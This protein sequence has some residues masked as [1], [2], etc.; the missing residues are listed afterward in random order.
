LLELS[1]D[2]LA[3]RPY[4]STTTAQRLV[5]GA[6]VPMAVITVWLSATSEHLRWP[7]ASALFWGWMIV[8]PMLTGLYWW[9]RRPAS[10]FGPLLVIFGAMVWLISWQASSTPLL[11]D[12]GVVAEGPYFL[13]T[14]YLFLAFPMG[15]LEPPAARWVMGYAWFVLLALF[16]PAL[17]LRPV[18]FGASPLA[19]CLP[20]CPE[21]ALQIGDSPDLA[22]TIYKW[23]TYA[24][25]VLVAAAF[26]VYLWRIRRATRP[27]RRALMAVAVTSL[28][29]LP[30]F[31][32]SNFAGWVLKLDQP[33]L[34]VLAWFVL[35]T[36]V[37]LPIGFLVALLQAELMAG[38]A[39]RSLLERLVARPS[40]REWRDAV[41][42]AVED[43]DVRIGYHDP[44][45]G[46]VREPDG[47]PLADGSPGRVWVPIE[48]A[49]APVAALVLDETLVEDPEL[50][51]AAG[52]ATLLAVE[53]GALEGEL[54][55]QIERDIHDTAQ[56]RLVALRIHLALAGEQSEDPRVF[57]GFD[58]QV[59][60]AIEELRGVA[61]GVVVAELARDGLAGALR[62]TAARSGLPVTVHARVARQ[63]PELESA[64]FFCC[65]E[66]LQNAAKHAG[67]GASVTI[68]V[69]DDGGALR[70]A[71][72]D[73]GRGFDPAMARRGAGLANLGERMAAAGG[74]LRIDSSPGHGTTIAGKL[75]LITLR[76]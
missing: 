38:R 52:T 74:E 33:V 28:L 43:P 59:E 69:R 27:Q 8:A 22:N 4:V 5:A 25:L 29:F 14:I 3:A 48:G 15:R 2:E 49:G 64:V 51:R 71:V 68:D 35:A 24:I 19:R 37:L 55:R 10:R 41:A 53:N 73:D 21:N 70:F 76:G 63:R 11:F 6:V 50:V 16:L 36:R 13:L 72:T 56:Q 45:T 18:I 61:H 65:V 34:D 7:A 42:A 17:L 54:R 32:V 46:V 9:V 58:E 60:Q 44:V 47:A 66:C 39:L 62:A 26:V 75:P 1:V 67:P 31:F 57:A 12:I 23:E 30:A 40:P 20:N